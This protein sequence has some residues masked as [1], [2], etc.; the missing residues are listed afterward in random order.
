[1]RNPKMG[2]GW[3][4]FGPDSY[5]TGEAAY[6]TIIGVQSTGVQACAKHLIANN[7]EHWR[8]GL[9]AD[10]D[11]RALREL[12]WWPFMRSIDAE[13]S[14]VM[15]AYNRFNQTSSCQNA[16]LLGPDGILRKDGFKGYVVS[17]WGATHDD[18]AV[19]ANHGLD[20]EQP[21]DWI[22]IGGG[23]FGNNLKSAVN[24]GDVPLSRLNGMV[25]RIL[26]PWFRLGQD[27]GFPETNFD[28]QKADGSG[29]LN[30]NVNV[31]SDAHT[32]LTREI[33]AASAVL[34]KNSRTT[35]T[36]TPTGTTTRGLPLAKSKLKSIAVIGQDARQLNQ[37]CPGGLN[38]CNDGT[39][40]IGWGSGSNSLDFV[41]PPIDAIKSYIGGSAIIT[42]SLSNDLKA[43]PKAAAG[44]DAAIVFVNAMSGELGFYSIVEG[45][46]GDRNDLALW[47][48]G[49]SLVEAVAAVNNNTIVVVHS[50]GPVNLQ[51]ANHPNV[52]AIIYH[53]AP[54]E[55]TGPAAVDVLFGDV[56][57]SGRLPFSIADTE[58]SYGTKIVTGIDGFPTI[59]YT[60]KLLIDYRYMDDKGITPRFEFGYGLSYTTFEYS[61]LSVS[62]SLISF[63]VKNTGVFDG[64]EI[65]QLYLTFPDGA[66]EPKKVLRGFEEVKLASGASQKVE[67]RLSEKEISVWDTPSQ[68][69][70]RP[71][72][73]YTVH[74][75]ASIKDIRLTGTF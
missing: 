44:K 35:D 5:L 2:R 27:Q 33:G 62:S 46:M 38:Q 66:G 39:M 3:E 15:C 24:K 7:Q 67:M 22:V 23:V 71:A 57:P 61:D 50:V 6:E 63:T 58:D 18:A 73:T 65:P 14:S 26:V 60:E 36:G 30:Q 10:V 1:M 68:S 32:A 70:K 56:N 20:M 41:V 13:V 37:N 16:G 51:W 21:G 40:V 12:Y 25:T 17:D 11:D 4:S 48:K 49:G 64:T 53:G 19:N 74:V 42:E 28:T 59:P 31:R 9:S 55:Q 52:S 47:W 72:G 75:G 45:N 43:G 8:Y 54:G 69:W 29:T 34:L